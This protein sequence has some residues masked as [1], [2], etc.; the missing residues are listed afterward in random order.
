MSLRYSN[1]II[2][3]IK[4]QSKDTPFKS[5]NNRSKWQQSRFPDTFGFVI[6]NGKN[7]N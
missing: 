5:F 6:N 4:R 1:S 2:H 3:A 7:D